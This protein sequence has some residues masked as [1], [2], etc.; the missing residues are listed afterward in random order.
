[1]IGRHYIEDVLLQLKKYKDLGERSMAQVT[2]EQFFEKLDP[3][4]NSIAL[5][6]KH[7]AGNMRSRWRDFLTKD[8]EKP[9][10]NRDAEFEVE[11]GDSRRSLMARWEEG[12]ALTLDAIGGLESG[13]LMKT[14]KIRGEP[15]TVLEAINRQV[16]H[17][18]SHIGQITLLAKHAAGA[19]WKSLSIPRG[20]S[21]D[22]EV[23]KVGRT[24][25]AG[26]DTNP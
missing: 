21:R 8:G 3:E 19:A 12:W 26:G 2:D 9:D 25:R 1:M 23:S 22:F 24:Y 16:S 7:L 17:Y 14:V 13:D 10:R 11:P 20:R 15:H 4:A 5:I 18:A 6:V